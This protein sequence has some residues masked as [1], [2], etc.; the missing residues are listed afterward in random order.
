MQT[1][2]FF[3]AEAQ[4][5]REEG[6]ELKG[7][8]VRSPF[9]FHISHWVP[10]PGSGAGSTKGR[11]V[12]SARHVPGNRTRAR[13][14]LMSDSLAPKCRHDP[15]HAYPFGPLSLGKSRACARRRGEGRGGR[16]GFIV[17]RRRCTLGGTDNEA[18][19]KGSNRPLSTTSCADVTPLRRVS[20]IR[21]LTTL[22]SPQWPPA[23]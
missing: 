14:R 4:R 6:K 10:A 7:D 16:T 18:S 19:P 3:T 20:R 8:R 21:S 2:R 11:C 22:V 9:R 23:R 13:K 12:F 1:R 5:R 15:P 17:R